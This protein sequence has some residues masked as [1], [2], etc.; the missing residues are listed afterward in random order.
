VM[1]KCTICRFIYEGPEAPD[2]CPKCGAP[3]EKF[4]KLGNEE[5]EL[6]IRSRSSNNLHIEAYTL[7][8]RLLEIAEK[9]VKDNLDPPCLRIFMEE[10]EFAIK[11]M[12][13]IKAELENHVLK[14]RWG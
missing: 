8:Q 4:M 13:K 3:K 11:T 9:G 14:G 1:W 6:I 7:L 10:R 5:E 2:K 12:Q